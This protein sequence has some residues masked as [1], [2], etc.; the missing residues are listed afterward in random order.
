MVGQL[1]KIDGNRSKSSDKRRKKTLFRRLLR[2]AK[3]HGVKLIHTEDSKI[4]KVM[5]APGDWEPMTFE[6][7]IAD[8]KLMVR[9]DKWGL[10]EAD[11]LIPNIN[12]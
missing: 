10:D 8:N 1:K 4:S 2:R 12:D 6:V 7:F 3:H 5:I 11:V 9:N